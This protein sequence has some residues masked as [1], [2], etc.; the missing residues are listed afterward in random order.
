MMVRLHK[1]LLPG[2][3]CFACVICAAPRDWGAVGGERDLTFGG[4]AQ[5]LWTGDF[6]EDGAAGNEFRVRRGRLKAAGEV[7]DDVQFKVLV[8]L[9]A[10]KI[11]QDFYFDYQVSDTFA[12]RAGQC[13]LPMG[14]QFYASASKK[15]FVD[16]TRTTGEFALGRDIGLMAHGEFGEGTLQY[17]MGVFNGSDKNARQDNTD[18]MYVWRLVVNPLGPVPLSE[19]DIKGS[20]PLIAFGVA[21]AFNTVT[22]DAGTDDAL[23]TVDLDIWTLGGELTFVYSGLYASSELFWRLSSP[24]DRPAGVEPAA[25]L[26]GIGAHV[27][28]GYFLVPGRLELGVRGAMV[29]KDVDVDDDDE[30]EA[31]PVVNWFFDGHKL[32]LQAD[33]AALLDEAPGADAVT[34]HRVRVQLQAA[35]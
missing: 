27:Q 19:S 13:K 6:D 23:A 20:G 31:G 15:Q 8:D 33:Y 12:L 2:M 11:L 34:D 25:D 7:S 17:Q 18:F 14:R 28:A 26:A 30:M 16:S 22:E 24:R 3:L 10:S 4:W 29:R 35:F 32:K 1:S 9:A 21:S 5:F